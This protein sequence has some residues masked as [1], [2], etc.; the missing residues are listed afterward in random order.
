MNEVIRF[1]RYEK[2]RELEKSSKNAK[3]F[4]PNAVLA[5]G[6]KVPQI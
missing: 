2:L 4:D 5:I 1:L 6:E 3:D